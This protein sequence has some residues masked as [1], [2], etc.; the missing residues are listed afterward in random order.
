MPL[1]GLMSPSR[2]NDGPGN[3]DILFDGEDVTNLSERELIVKLANAQFWIYDALGKL[4]REVSRLSDRVSA[5][6]LRAQHVEDSRPDLDAVATMSR[7]QATGVL[8][9]RDLAEFRKGRT[10]RVKLWYAVAAIAA[11]EIAIRILT[12]LH[13]MK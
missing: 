3:R 2:R 13:V 10:G 4:T 6:E 7:K 8:D 11:G 5:L 1:R 12:A 9:E